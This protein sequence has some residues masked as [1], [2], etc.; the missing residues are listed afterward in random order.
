MIYPPVMIIALFKELVMYIGLDMGGT[1][2]D[3]VIINNKTVVAEAKVPTNHKNFSSSIEQALAQLF[4][5]SKISSS[6]VTR[7]TFGST[8]AINA[9]V[10]N[11]QSPVGLL[12]GAGPGINPNWFTI[13]EHSFLTSAKLDHR[14]IE[15]NPLQRGPLQT[16]INEWKKNGINT[17]ACVSKFSIRNPKHEN[18]ME[19]VIQ[20]IF[21]HYTTPV[22]SKGH[23]LSGSL[24]F[25]RRITT[26][27]WNAAVWDIHNKFIT[28]IELVLKKFFINAPTFL[29]KA[30][31]G[32]IPLALS[33]SIPIEAIHS[34][35][36]A[37]IMGLI[38]L[39][40]TS[41]TCLLL[42]IGGTTTD[43]SIIVKGKPILSTSGLIIQKKPTLIRA[44]ASYSIPLGGDSLVNIQ[45]VD[46]IPYIKVGPLREGPAM[47]FDGEHPTFL[48]CLNILGYA[49]VGNITK[50]YDGISLLSKKYNITP[51][52]IAQSVVY[53]A[54]QL[55]QEG[56]SHLLNEINS[57]PIHTIEALLENHN[58]QP[59][60][61]IVTGGPASSIKPL[62]NNILN[63]P[64]ITP[65][66]YTLVTNAIGAALT[67]PTAVLELYANT[68]R[69]ICLV[70]FLNIQYSIPSS[71]S[72]KEACYDA[73]NI[74]KKYLQDTTN[75]TI[76]PIIDIIEAQE[77]STLDMVGKKGKD[78]R[79][80]CQVRP[81]LEFSLN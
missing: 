23:M 48:D 66:K 35:P 39:Y 69:Q 38:A 79:V 20:K 64:I 9:I 4:F 54:Q 1:H 36:S 12:L 14:G 81:E 76:S 32:S 52:D 62:L 78:I 28:S 25:P 50:S 41:E 53:S 15:L 57:K 59:T 56:I 80:V 27:Y 58:V 34:G 47:A 31:G 10:Q 55:L 49:Q 45:L 70:P 21:E 71:Y 18:D 29:L 11:K 6:L 40:P 8:L 51:Q 2:T 67:K 30:D 42:D 17:F 26:A 7:I 72:L 22:V 77:F 33:R 60:L 61:C 74:L 13:G 5:T 68:E 43:I 3:A 63:L 46:G 73:S 16:C 19:L 65:S 44:L 75:T 37:S 24:N